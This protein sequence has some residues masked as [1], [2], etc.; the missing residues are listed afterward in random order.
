MPHTQAPRVHTEAV[1]LDIGEDVGALIIYTPPDWLGREIEMSP[2]GTTKRTHTDVVERHW[3]GQT[4]FTAVFQTVPIGD[5]TLWDAAPGQPGVVAIV[6]GT[7]T[8]LD[9]R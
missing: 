9:W 1:V 3:N 5:Y 4:L 6:G 8:E 2:Q 7:I